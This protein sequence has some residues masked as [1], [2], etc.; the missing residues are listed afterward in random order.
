[1]DLRLLLEPEAKASSGRVRERRM[2]S[3]GQCDKE[4]EWSGKPAE[5]D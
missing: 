1:M 4:D 3:H 5:A 2:E